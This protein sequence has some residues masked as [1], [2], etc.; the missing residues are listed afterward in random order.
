VKPDAEDANGYTD[1]VSRSQFGINFASQPGGH[2]M[3]QPVLK[4]YCGIH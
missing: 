4:I 3:P 1:K 2:E